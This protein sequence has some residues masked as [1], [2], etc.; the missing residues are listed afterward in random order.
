LN[1]IQDP[2]FKREAICLIAYGT[3]RVPKKQLMRL[4]EIAFGNLGKLGIFQGYQN[5]TLNRDALIGDDT[6]RND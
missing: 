3:L 6:D 4:L 5:P 2:V 1:L